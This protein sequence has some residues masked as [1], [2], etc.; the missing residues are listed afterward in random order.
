MTAPPPPLFVR[1]FAPEV[2]TADF[3]ELIEQAG[4]RLATDSILFVHLPVNRS[5]GGARGYGFVQCA[6]G[7]VALAFRRTFHLNM[8]MR[9]RKLKVTIAKQKTTAVVRDHFS[10]VEPCEGY[11]PMVAPN[12]EYDFASSAERRSEGDP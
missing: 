1:S 7:E 2:K 6:T 4:F 8:S 12:S 11:T 9:K 5:N 3:V 10:K